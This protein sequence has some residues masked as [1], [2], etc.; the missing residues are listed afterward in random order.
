MPAARKHT[1]HRQAH[2]DNTNGPS[3]NSGGD[4]PTKSDA[5]GRAHSHALGAHSDPQ[6]CTR[7][8]IKAGNTRM[9]AAMDGH[10]HGSSLDRRS[11][12]TGPAHDSRKASQQL[13]PKRH[14]HRPALSR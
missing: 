14:T 12:Q 10:K 5:D 11:R 1:A 4:E 7:A 2:G 3:K 9:L 13:T 8:C 6:K